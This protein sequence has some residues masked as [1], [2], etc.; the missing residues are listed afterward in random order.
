[1]TLSIASMVELGHTH[2]VFPRKCHGAVRAWACDSLWAAQQMS[3]CCCAGSPR[4]IT[5]IEE[6]EP[7]PGPGG[8]RISKM[9]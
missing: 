6:L 3:S 9:P 7:A 1:M 4:M 5:T 2:V 8:P